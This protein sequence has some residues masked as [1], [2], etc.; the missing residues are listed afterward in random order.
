MHA[1]ELA[2]R[3]AGFTK[4]VF[5]FGLKKRG[6]ERLSSMAKSCWPIMGKQRATGDHPCFS[7]TLLN[8]PSNTDLYISTN[9]PF[10]SDCQSSA[11]L[12]QS[13]QLARALHLRFGL[14][15]S[16]TSGGRWLTHEDIMSKTA[17][18]AGILSLFPARARVSIRVCIFVLFFFSFQ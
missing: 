1:Y 2:F 15:Y 4:L 14:V 6:A 12:G 16:L 11:H 8:S 13:Q 7:K 10:A 18:P 3:L 9:N 17:P 5:N